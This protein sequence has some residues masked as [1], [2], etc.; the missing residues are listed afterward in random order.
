MEG[1]ALSSR[2]PT[3][4]SRPLMYSSSTVRPPRASP[5]VRDR[6]SSSAVWAMDT[7]MEEP[8]ATGLTTRGKRAV[9]T[10]R[11]MSAAV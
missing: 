3:W 1:R 2:M 4:I 11:S 9:S 5:S 8:L 10:S 6:R 7:P